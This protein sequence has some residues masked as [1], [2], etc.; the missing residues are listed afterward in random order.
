HEKL[1]DVAGADF[2]LLRVHHQP[3][4][5]VDNAF[6]L[7]HGD[8]P[9]LRGV[10]EPGEHL[11]A[12]EFLPAPVLLDHHV[13]DFVQALV[14][15]EAL[16]AGETLTPATDSLAFLALAR[17]HH[18]II[19]V[20]AKRAFHGTAESSI[21]YM[22]RAPGFAARLVLLE[23]ARGSRRSAFRLPAAP[24]PR[25]RRPARGSQERFEG[26]YAPVRGGAPPGCGVYERMD[27][28]REGGAGGN[29]GAGSGSWRKS[30]V[31]T[32]R[33]LSRQLAR[34]ST[35]S[36]SMTRVPNKASSSWRAAVPILRIISPPWPIRIAFCPGRSQ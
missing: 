16:L 32:Q 28:P 15:S 34:T 9:L 36:S 31:A 18:P 3:L 35:R 5:L 7:P 23:S 2:A 1:A 20:A 33:G 8:R 30:R 12:I 11:L 29:S 26:S 4:D 17:I 10:Q 27:R 21:Y 14:G 6:Q 13:G 22:R 24:G 25:L 19:Q